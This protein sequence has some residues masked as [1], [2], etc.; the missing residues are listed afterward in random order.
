M[1]FAGL[2]KIDNLE[3]FIETV[4]SFGIINNEFA[5]ITIGFLFPWIEIFV[6]ALLIL[7]LWNNLACVLGMILVGSIIFAFGIFPEG[8]PFN[9]DVI[10]FFVF[11]ALMFSGPGRLSLD[12]VKR[13]G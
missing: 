3:Q 1:L 6:S 4:K 10:I 7:G 2:K 5:N 8:V 12:G 9:K 11:L 13:T